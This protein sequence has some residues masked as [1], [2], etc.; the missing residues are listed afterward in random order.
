MFPGSLLLKKMNTM[1]VLFYSKHVYDDKVIIN[2]I[3]KSLKIP[4][5]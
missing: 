5:G 4:K 1:R 2:M 3:K